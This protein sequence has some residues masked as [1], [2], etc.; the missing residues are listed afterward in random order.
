MHAPPNILEYGD[1]DHERRAIFTIFP[2]KSAALA[3]LQL[4]WHTY[5]RRSNTIEMLAFQ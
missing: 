1:G 3:L 4:A 2:I 5:Q